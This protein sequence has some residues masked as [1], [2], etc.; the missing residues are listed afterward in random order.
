MTRLPA[1]ARLERLRGV[2]DSPRL[3]QA[4]RFALVGSQ[5]ETRRILGEEIPAAPGHRVLDVCCGIGEFAG[6]VTSG[7]I[8]VDLNARF[9][10]HARRRFPDR[11]VWH[12][13]AGD[14]TRL[15]LPDEAV[16][17]SMCVNSLHHFPDDAAVALLGE[18][19]R[20]TRGRVIVVDADGT[21][22]GLLR[23][24]L[25]ALDRGAHMR[26]PAALTALVGRVLE[27]EA[28]RRWDVGPYT[29]V[30]LRCA[31]RGPGRPAVTGAA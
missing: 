22:R 20:V 15:P 26:T 12:F 11:R 31:P 27:V 1:I 30:L 17:A 16:E 4:F 5:R 25:L 7:Y 2:L 28:T 9:V 21:P 19:R 10:A 24:T 18:M 14:A 3:F 6:V 23:R 29:E 13:Q 8:G